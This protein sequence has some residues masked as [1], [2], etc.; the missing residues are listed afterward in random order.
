MSVGAR[1][2][3]ADSG[4]RPLKVGLILP[5]QDDGMADATPLCSDLSAMAERAE[6]IGF[7]SLWLADHPLF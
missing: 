7:D 3:A 5:V 1:E 4:G 6:Q 2:A